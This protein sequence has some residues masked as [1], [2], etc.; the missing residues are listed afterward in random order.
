MFRRSLLH[1]II[2]CA[3]AVTPGAA[4]NASDLSALDIH[5]LEYP[6]GQFMLHL[7]LHA[8]GSVYSADQPSAARLNASGATGATSLTATIDRLYDSGFSIALKSVFNLSHDQLSGDIYGNKVVEKFYANI[9][10]GLGRI[11]IGNVDGAAY[12]LAVTGPVVDEDVSLEESKITFFRD[13]STRTAFVHLFPVKTAVHASLNYAKVSY[14]TPRL[15]GIEFALSFTPSEGRGVIPFSANG[16]IVANHQDN[17]WEFVG[18]YVGYYGA[19]SIGAYSGLAVGH[20]AAKTA[21]HEGLTEWAVGAEIDYAVNDS[22][23]VAVGGAFHQTNAYAFNINSV[24]SGRTTHASH[25]STVVSDGHWLIGMEYSDGIAHGTVGTSTISTVGYEG[26]VGYKMNA[27]IQI[28][29][30]WERQNFNRTTGV[31]YNGLGRIHMDA[32]F[33]HIRF[34]V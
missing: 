31:F 24:F 2:I 26:S 25:L 1:K 32:A 5:P 6:V 3:V 4:A 17:M 19:F 11:E 29:A 13:P 12:E 27:N 18:S 16:P 10:P 22:L 8:N 7:G 28:T 14:Y 9:K 15:F 21:L 20:N 23:K 34:D 33:L 30:G